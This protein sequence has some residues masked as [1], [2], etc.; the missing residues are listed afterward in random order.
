M[1]NSEQIRR[2]YIDYFIS[3][4]HKELPSSSLIP[5]GDATLLLTTAGMVQFKP[6][7]LGEGTPPARRLTTCQK[8]FRTTDIDSVGDATHLTFFEMLGNFS[9]GDYFKKEAISFAWEFVTE[10]LK[11]PEEKLYVTVYLDDDEAVKCW[12]ELGVPDER[13]VRCDAKDNFWG[14]A[15]DSGPCGPCSEIHYDY[16]T[17]HGCQQPNC[18]PSCPCQRFCEIWNLVFVQYD[19]Q[20]DGTRVALKAPSIDTGMGLERVSAVIQ[21]KKTVYDTDIFSELLPLVCQIIGKN[22]RVNEVD[23]H[24][25]RIITEHGRAVTFLVTDG[26]LPSNEGRGYVLKRMLRRAA[27]VGHRL[28]V[29]KPFLG[30]IVDCVVKKL[31]AVY[32]ELKERQA[33]VK[34]VIVREEE[35]F[36]ETLANGLSV[37]REIVQH[38]VDKK[39]D[40][41]D[42]FKLYDTYGFPAELSAEV[43]AEQGF[44]L[45]YEGFNREMAIQKE[46]SKKGAK[47]HNADLALKGALGNHRTSYSGQAVL[48]ETGAKILVLTDGQE[49]VEFLAE[50]QSGGV[51]IDK[52]SFY[53][54]MGGQIGD[55]GYIR[56]KTGLFRVFNA[57]H[58]GDAILH[59]GEMIEGSFTEGDI[60]NTEVDLPAREATERNH[61][62]THILHSALRHLLGEHIQQRG[63]MVDSFRLRF[64]FSHLTA[65]TETELKN[66]TELVNTYIM[67]ATPVT[68]TETPYKDAL[69]AGVVALFGEKYGDLVRVVQMNSISSE[70]CGG[71]HVNNSGQIGSFEIIS[72]SSI[73]GGVRRIEAVTGFNT[74]R[75]RAQNEAGLVEALNKAEAVV[76]EKDRELKKALGANAQAEAKRLTSSA[77]EANGIK[78]V[79]AQINDYE[80]D[81]MRDMADTIKAGLGECVVFLSS[82]H[83]S[84]P[85]FVASV[86]D[87]LIRDRG[88]KAGELVKVATL[89]C[90]GGGGGRA[91]MATGG[92]QDGDKLPAALDAVRALIR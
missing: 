91:Q 41:F 4:G 90:G 72:E 6:Y 76:A 68:A 30:R 34:E 87:G 26:V 48:K 81:I 17:D 38:S 85:L 29:K 55:S 3:K 71:C 56:S 1:M 35:R 10:E 79:V 63:S 23:D 9:I 37:L 88:L 43:A 51:I 64:D 53:G 67:S 66:I 84:K 75:W 80:I 73:A 62:A 14:P 11:L 78:N 69:K 36:S 49:K 32:P 16:G 45:D 12:Q 2:K 5:H 19:Q 8:C 18:S 28:G 31:G 92:G 7:F 70:L 52:T 59:E 58:F 50:S 39:I 46:K 27:L 25:I 44:T 60:V 24:F 77:I 33:F 89:V 61:T 54:E 47:F 82:L 22:Y 57:R 83:N 40:G 21:G 86:S 74:L 15:G 13:I 42:A 65:L 20:K